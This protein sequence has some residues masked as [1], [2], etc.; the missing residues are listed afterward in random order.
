MRF[1]SLPVAAVASVLS[2]TVLAAPVNV[3]WWDS[4]P[5]Y[6]GQAPDALR[7]QMSDY[8]TAFGRR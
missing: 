7:Q 8:L 4:T 3:L 2:G 6:G 5:E 1:M